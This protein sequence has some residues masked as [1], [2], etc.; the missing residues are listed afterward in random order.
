LFL[1]N[2]AQVEKAVHGN[3]DFVCKSTNATKFSR[4]YNISTRI[5][6]KKRNMWTE[7]RNVIQI[8]IVQLKKLKLK[9]NS[10]NPSQNYFTEK[11]TVHINVMLLLLMWTLIVNIPLLPAASV[12]IKRWKGVTPALMFLYFTLYVIKIILR[13]Y[14]ISSWFFCSSAFC[15]NKSVIFF[16]TWCSKFV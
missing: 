2:G 6:Q 3:F 15:Q 8:L 11:S 13:W 5:S 1:H 14:Q 9:K 4:I 7:V 16:Y 12:T 10:R